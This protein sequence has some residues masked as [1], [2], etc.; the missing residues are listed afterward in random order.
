[1]QALL[2]VLEVGLE[3]VGLVA[4]SP[5]HVVVGEEAAG[6]LDGGHRQLLLVVVIHLQRHAHKICILPYS[7]QLSGKV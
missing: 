4:L 7:G 6:V 3:S 5:G 1:M 2:C